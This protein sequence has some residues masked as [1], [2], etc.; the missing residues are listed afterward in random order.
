[1]HTFR[2]FLV[3]LGMLLAGLIITGIIASAMDSNNIARENQRAKAHA[4]Q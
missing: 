4:G 3:F 2:P 1:M